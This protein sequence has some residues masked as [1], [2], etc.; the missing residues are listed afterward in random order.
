[1]FA[2]VSLMLGDYHSPERAMVSELMLSHVSHV[3]AHAAIFSYEN[4]F[5]YN[6]ISLV[7][8]LVK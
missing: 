4:Q 2:Y 5:S 8:V 3:H 7:I 1:M 6:F